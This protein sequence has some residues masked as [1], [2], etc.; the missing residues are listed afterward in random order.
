MTF[1]FAGLV[2]AQIDERMSP[3]LDVVLLPVLLVIGAASVIHWLATER[4]GVGN[5][6]PCA[7]LQACTMA[8]VLLLAFTH[9]S[10]C[11]RASDI[12]W[13]FGAYVAAKITET[14]DVQIWEWTGGLVSGHT[15]KHFFAA[16][17]GVI[18][19]ITLLRRRPQSPSAVA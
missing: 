8:A 12:Y 15:L 7:I 3:R 16:L 4:A 18:V 13:V 2:A 5:V 11:T 10:R 6:M 14:P 19:C 9:P 17:S 1:A